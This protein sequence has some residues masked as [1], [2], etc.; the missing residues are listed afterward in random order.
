MEHHVR[1]EDFYNIFKEKKTKFKSAV[2]YF[3]KKSF[4]LFLN[5]FQLKSFNV[6]AVILQV[7][8]TLGF[9]FGLKVF[10]LL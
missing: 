9:F 10:A 6:A 3:K 2:T 8:A 1:D 5:N 7:A 4:N